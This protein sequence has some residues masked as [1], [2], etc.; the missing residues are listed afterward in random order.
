VKQPKDTDNIDA[1]KEV[2]GLSNN[3]IIV[4][5]PWYSYNN[6]IIVFIIAYGHS[7]GK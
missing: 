7:A 5:C 4:Q 6:I 1:S 2:L 3:N